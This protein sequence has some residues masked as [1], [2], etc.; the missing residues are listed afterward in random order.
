VL[1]A[2]CEAYPKYT[3]SERMGFDGLGLLALSFDSGVRVK[4]QAWHRERIEAETGK[5]GEPDKRSKAERAAEALAGLRSLIDTLPEGSTERV[6]LEAV[7]A[8]R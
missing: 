1:D 2:V 6:R 3:P 5:S 8:K 7:L 4:A